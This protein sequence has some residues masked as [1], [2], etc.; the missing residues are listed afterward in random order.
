MFKRL[1]TMIAVGA[2]NL[3]NQPQPYSEG[4]S[5]Y[6]QELVTKPDVLAYDQLGLEGAYGTSLATK[7]PNIAEITCPFTG[8]RLTAVAALTPDV[9]VIH[10]QR[11][12]L[13]ADLISGSPE[14][15]RVRAVRE[16]Y[17]DF[18]LR[19]PL[20]DPQDPSGLRSWVESSLDT[21]ALREAIAASPAA[22]HARCARRPWFRWNLPFAS[23]T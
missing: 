10:A 23:A 8:E 12:D 19:D 2:A 13:L 11:A 21:E 4:G 5:P 14:G 7:T 18:L 22:Q 1:L 20:F 16:A 15:Q 6:N 3:N 9:T 17:L